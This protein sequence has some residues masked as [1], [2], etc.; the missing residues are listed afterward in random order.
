M[1][2]FEPLAPAQPEAT[3][4]AKERFRKLLDRVAATIQVGT[5][6]VASAR[7][8]GRGALLADNLPDAFRASYLENRDFE[9]DPLIIATRTASQP[10]RSQ[11]VRAAAEADPDLMPVFLAAAE[12]LGA[13]VV[14][15]PV[16]LRGRLGG[17]VVFRRRGSEFG[18]AEVDHL[19]LV[20]PA[21]YLAAMDLPAAAPQS[22]LTARERE[23][24]AWTSVGKTAWEIGSILGISEH[25]AVAHLNAAVRKLGAASRAQAVAEALRRGLIE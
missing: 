8:A 4:E 18:E 12:A 6:I 20:A 3:S 5:Y 16:R 10:V 13:A 14:M 11:D 24:L 23:C 9:R 7:F 21:L 15:I 17:V 2:R 22:D 25:T 19:E 1:S